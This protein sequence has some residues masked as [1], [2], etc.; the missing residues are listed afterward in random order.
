MVV[1]ALTTG[2]AAM[3]YTRSIYWFENLFDRMPGNDYIRHALGMAVVGV[4]TYLML[5]YFG[6]SYIEGVG[7]ATIQDVLNG[8]LTAG[9][10]PCS[11]CWRPR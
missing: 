1:T 2:V 6:H 7:Y 10:W 8:G 4:M 5:R 3:I 9:G 11:S